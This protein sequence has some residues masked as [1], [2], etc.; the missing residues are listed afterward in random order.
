M[1]LDKVRKDLMLSVSMLERAGIIDFNGHCSIRLGGNAMAIN[2]GRSVRSAL[3][4]EDIV[5]IDFDG[6]LLD[7]TDAPPM[8]FHLHAGMYRN[9]ADVNAVVH[10]H[11]RYSRLFTMTGRKIEPVFPQGALLGDMPVF[12][13]PMSINTKDRGDAVATMIGNGRAGLLPSHGAILVGADICEAFAL[14]IYLEDNAKSQYEAEAL[15]APYV[16]SG[17]DLEI[18]N[19]NLWNPKLFQKCWDYH[20]ACLT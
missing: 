12:T 5:A 9:R 8:E 14:T 10:A 4:E 1:I 3:K 7:G 2:S 17:K 20:A 16:F 11:P 15:G 19:K 18:C 13:D 6:N